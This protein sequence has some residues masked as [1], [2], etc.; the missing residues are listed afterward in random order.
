MEMLF[1][2][3][4]SP[5]NWGL[6]CVI[7]GFVALG[8]GIQLLQRNPLSDIPFVGGELGSDEKRRAVYMSN[9]HE[10][11]INGLQR[12]GSLIF[13]MATDQTSGCMADKDI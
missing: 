7:A 2:T 9:G 6:A 10:I 1:L 12:V 4:L 11:Y 8:L 3:S 5:E 13:E